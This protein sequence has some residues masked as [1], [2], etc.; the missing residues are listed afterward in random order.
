MSGSINIV[1]GFWFD[2]SAY[3][4]TRHPREIPSIGDTG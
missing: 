2:F 3:S 4:R 1:G